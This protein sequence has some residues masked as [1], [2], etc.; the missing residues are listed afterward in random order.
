[1]L[2]DTSSYLPCA[3]GRPGDKVFGG[4]YSWR[5]TWLACTYLTID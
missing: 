2:I 4:C 1:M 5:H 3:Q